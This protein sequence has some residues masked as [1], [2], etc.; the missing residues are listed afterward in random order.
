[1]VAK[2]SVCLSRQVAGQAKTLAFLGL[3]IRVLRVRVKDGWRRWSQIG[4]N[5]VL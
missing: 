4:N 5:L 2:G 1:M 3:I